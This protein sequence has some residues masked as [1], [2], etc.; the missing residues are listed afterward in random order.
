MCEPARRRG[1]Q[2]VGQCVEVPHVELVV[3]GAAEADADEV[4]GEQGGND[5]WV[6]IKAKGQD[7]GRTGGQGCPQRRGAE[8]WGSESALA[9]PLFYTRSGPQCW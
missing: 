8:V 9:L 3:Q 5:L 1:P 7:Q 2:E 4:G 6:M